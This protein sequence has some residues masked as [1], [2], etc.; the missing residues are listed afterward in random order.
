MDP[1]SSTSKPLSGSVRGGEVKLLERCNAYLASNDL[2]HMTYLIEEVQHDYWHNWQA[3]I[4][5]HILRCARMLV[6]LRYGSKRQ[7]KLAPALR[8]N[9]PIK[10]SHRH[11]NWR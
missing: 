1:T 9:T 5:Q 10:L 6:A 2:E 4:V 11:Q 8:S 3:P 7:A